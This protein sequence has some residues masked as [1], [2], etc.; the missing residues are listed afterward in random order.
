MKSFQ[1]L[2]KGVDKVIIVYYNVS[3]DN[4]IKK[5]GGLD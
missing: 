1:R 5:S 2:P 4:K 3:V